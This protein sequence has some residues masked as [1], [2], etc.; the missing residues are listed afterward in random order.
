[1][2]CTVREQSE[3]TVAPRVNVI[4]NTDTV[5][6]EADLPGVAKDGIELDVRDGEL[7]LTGHRPGAV[8]EGTYAIRERTLADYHRIFR[9]SRAIDSSKVQAEMNG[10]VLT[11]TLHKIDA[12]KPRKIDVN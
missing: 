4:D 6:I 1:M 2:T 7:V 3:K 12:V 10:G 5:L 11:V 8:E 9:L